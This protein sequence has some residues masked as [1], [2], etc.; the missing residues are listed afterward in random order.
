MPIVLSRALTLPPEFKLFSSGVREGRLH[1][2]E[3]PGL[4]VCAFLAL[5]A[6][7]SDALP[8]PTEL[9]EMPQVLD[10]GKATTI[11]SCVSCLGFSCAVF[12]P[13][14]RLELSTGHPNGFLD[15]EI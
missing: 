14:G 9:P 7:Y 11:A 8:T 5:E 10:N 1:Y 2:G 15:I 6:A 12:S 3:L 13:F 4:L